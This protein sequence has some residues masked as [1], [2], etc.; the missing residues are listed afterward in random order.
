MASR[1]LRQI[2]RYVQETIYNTSD[3][4]VSSSLMFFSLI[5]VWRPNRFRQASSDDFCIVYNNNDTVS[6]TPQIMLSI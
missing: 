3:P 4:S 2:I 1:Q 6:S 5:V